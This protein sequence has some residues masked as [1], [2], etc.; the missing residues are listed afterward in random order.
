MS[1]TPS[2]TTLK[3]GLAFWGAALCWATSFL[4]IKIGLQDWNPISLVAARLTTAS[5]LFAVFLTVVGKP[6]R[7]TKRELV[8]FA[9]VAFFNPYLPFLLISWGEQ[10]ISSGMASILNATVPLFMLVVAPILLPDEK[11]TLRT[12]L[13]IVVG[14]SGVAILFGDPRPASDS[15]PGFYL[16]GVLAVIVASLSYA[17]ATAFLRRF[18]FTT[19]PLYQA[20]LMNGFACAF[21]L[22]HGFA[23]GSLIAPPLPSSWVAFLWLGTL[24]SF[25]AYTLAMYVLVHRGATLVSLTNF[26]Y[27][28]LGLFLGV[29]FLGE[30]FSWRIL[31]GGLLILAGI[32]IVRFGAKK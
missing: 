11:P 16:A 19:P 14:F 7:P 8:V 20:A 12:F 5:V 22:V 24:G 30:P 26:A 6:F 18:R 2:V 10:Y 15:A 1:A 13:G 25:L 17:L 9:I 3:I 23:S 31:A 29:I 27:P 21:I 32:G 28:L 4:W